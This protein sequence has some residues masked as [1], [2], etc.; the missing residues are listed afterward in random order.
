MIVGFMLARESLEED[1]VKILHR[2]FLEVCASKIKAQ[3]KKLDSAK[4]AREGFHLR[5]IYILETFAGYIQ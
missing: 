2:H 3:H 5:N 1:D 4:K